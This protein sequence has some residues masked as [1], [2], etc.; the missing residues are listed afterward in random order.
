MHQYHKLASAG[1]AEG[2][3]NFSGLP[4]F[5]FFATST[6]NII[7]PPG[8]TPGGRIVYRRTLR[9]VETCNAIAALAGVGALEVD[10]V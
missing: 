4:L 3:P 9:P 2:L 7:E 1:N 10:H 8:L 5:D 6:F